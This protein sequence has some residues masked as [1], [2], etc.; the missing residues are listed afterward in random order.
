MKVV[1]F[2]T[3]TVHHTYFVRELLREYEVDAV[4]VEQRLCRALFDTHHGF[5]DDRNDFGVQCCPTAID[6][7]NDINNSLFD[8]RRIM[9]A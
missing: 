7:T 6:G 3:Q 5:E 4:F 9:A 1:V 8:L 2:T